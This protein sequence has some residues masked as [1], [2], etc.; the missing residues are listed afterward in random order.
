MD[1]KGALRAAHLHC[2]NNHILKTIKN[3]KH[4]TLNASDNYFDSKK[5]S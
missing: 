3:K 5:K 2:Q 1:G 4:D